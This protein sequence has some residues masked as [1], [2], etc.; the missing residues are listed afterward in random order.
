MSDVQSG[1]NKCCDRLHVH[2]NGSSRTCQP[3]S[4]ATRRKLITE[5]VLATLFAA[6]TLIRRHFARR[7]TGAGWQVTKDGYGDLYLRHG[8]GATSHH[9]GG[10]Y[11]RRCMVSNGKQIAFLSDAGAKSGQ[12]ADV[13]VRR[14]LAGRRASERSEGFLASSRL[15]ARPA[16]A[17]PCSLVTRKC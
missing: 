17:R 3:S 15:V 14:T 4:F 12:E 7:P 2:G 8:A 5:R 9:A 16:T 11:E 1:K 6:K 13:V 10:K